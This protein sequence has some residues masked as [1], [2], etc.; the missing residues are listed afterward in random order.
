M[1]KLSENQ[2]IEKAAEPASP[3]R[4]QGALLYKQV[5]LG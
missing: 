3:S 2:G 1:L 5:T 4:G